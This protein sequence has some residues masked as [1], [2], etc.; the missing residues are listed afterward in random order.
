M[1]KFWEKPLFERLIKFKLLAFLIENLK[2]LTLT[3]TYYLCLTAYVLSLIENIYKI[4]FK[5]SIHPLAM[6]CQEEHHPIFTT[7][8]LPTEAVVLEELKVLGPR[9]TLSLQD[10]KKLLTIEEG[11]I[12][13]DAFT[14]SQVWYRPVENSKVYSW[15]KISILTSTWKFNLLKFVSLPLPRYIPST[16]GPS[17]FADTAQLVS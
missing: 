15:L 6:E 7:S 1:Y 16:K 10:W 3:H 12:G 5:K 4:K 14:E 9:A 13:E 8:N 2:Q 11:R 17:E